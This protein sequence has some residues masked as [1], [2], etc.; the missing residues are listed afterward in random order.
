MYVRLE[1]AHTGRYL[2]DKLKVCLRELG[3]DKKVCLLL[4]APLLSSSIVADT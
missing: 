2:A 3:I 4:A 1:N